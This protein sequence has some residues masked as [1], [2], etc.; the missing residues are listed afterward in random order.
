MET[1]S[2]ISPVDVTS[3]LLARIEIHDISSTSEEVELP[4][5]LQMVPELRTRSSSSK[6]CV[7]K[8]VRYLKRKEGRKEDEHWMDN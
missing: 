1:P 7:V 6:S 5:G 4:D 8:E 2:A 3:H